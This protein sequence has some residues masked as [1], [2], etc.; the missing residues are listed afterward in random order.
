MGPPPISTTP[1][2]IKPSIPHHGSELKAGSYEERE[3]LATVGAALARRDPSV[4]GRREQRRGTPR[5]VETLLGELGCW[6]RPNSSPTWSTTAALP[7]I[8]VVT[9]LLSG[10][11]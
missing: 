6:N 9:P 10:N 11:R 4:I 3:K 2:L 5:V 8:V 7:L 1:F